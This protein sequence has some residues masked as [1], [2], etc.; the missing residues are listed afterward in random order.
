MFYLNA[1]SAHGNIVLYAYQHLNHDK[2]SHIINPII[3]QPATQPNEYA[4]YITFFLF[5]IKIAL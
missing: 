4:I 1:Q 5:L 2:I 3:I